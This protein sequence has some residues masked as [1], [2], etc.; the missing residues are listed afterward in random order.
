MSPNICSLDWLHLLRGASDTF[1]VAL[2][3]LGKICSLL[4]EFY[5]DDDDDDDDDDWR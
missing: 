3:N 1:G 5:G 4:I 2:L